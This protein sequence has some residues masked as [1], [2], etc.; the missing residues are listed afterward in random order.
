MARYI[1][2][3]K[4]IQAIIKERDKIPLTIPCAYYE[5]LDVKPNSDGQ[6][7]RAGIRKALRC[8]AEAPTADVVEV[9]RCKDCTEWDK[10]ECECSHWYG[11]R[12]ND[13]CSNGVKR[14]ETNAE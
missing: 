12:E 9:V 14:S 13:F 4:L 10:N 8:I 5:L 7:Q 2:E 6:S 3:S 11:F 1:N